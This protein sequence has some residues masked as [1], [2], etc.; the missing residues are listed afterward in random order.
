MVV[1][2]VFSWIFSLRSGFHVVRGKSVRSSQGLRNNEDRA[3][4]VVNN[5]GPDQSGFRQ[6]L[7]IGGLKGGS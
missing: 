6:A 7:G 1:G 5:Q 4:G 3:G 2:L